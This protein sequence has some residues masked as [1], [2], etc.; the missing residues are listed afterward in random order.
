MSPEP[1]TKMQHHLLI[2]ERFSRRQLLSAQLWSPYDQLS[3]LHVV[4]NPVLPHSL[5]WV[6]KLAQHNARKHPMN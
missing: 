1:V 4:S 2:H 5:I 6:W 3:V